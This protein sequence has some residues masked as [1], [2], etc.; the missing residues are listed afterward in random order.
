MP[1]HRASTVPCLH[2]NEVECPAVTQGT[3]THVACSSAQYLVLNYGPGRY[4]PALQSEC[5]VHYQLELIDGSV[6]DTTYKT[7]EPQRFS[8]INMI[9]AW[10]E[11]LQMMVVG[12]RYQ[13]VVPSEL[14]YGSAGNPPYIPGGAVL[15]FK[16][17]LLQIN[18]TQVD[19]GR[20]GEPMLTCNVTTFDGCIE[21]EHLFIKSMQAKLRIK[22]WPAGQSPREKLEREI[23][24]VARGPPKQADVD[25]AQ[26]VEP[27]TWRPPEQDASDPRGEPGKAQ[28]EARVRRDTERARVGG[29]RFAERFRAAVRLHGAVKAL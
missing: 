15:V 3:L 21:R 14:G 28:G 24:R 17:E 22:P 23:E 18:G 20:S 5:L 8:P 29:S 27:K 16:M 11:A 7:K 19:A 4:H 26:D 25:R 9:P 6:V 13:L 10:T 2:A 1:K 12:D